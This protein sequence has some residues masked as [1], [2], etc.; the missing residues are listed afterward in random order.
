M[1][2]PRR[3]KWDLAQDQWAQQLNP[4]LANPLNNG[5]ILKNVSLINGTTVVNHMLGRPLQGWKIIRQRAAASIYDVQD[6]NQM[7]ES[8][9][10]LVSD[11][12]VVVN[13]EVF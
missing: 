6:S 1:Q 2:L 11:A 10:L 5:S 9:L 13:L 8:T 3:I 4:L 12:A 7:P